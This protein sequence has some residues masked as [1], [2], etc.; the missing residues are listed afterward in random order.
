MVSESSLLC[1]S[2]SPSSILEESTLRALLQAGAVRKVGTPLPSTLSLG[3]WCLPGRGRPQLCVTK[4]ILGKCGREVYSPTPH[5]A[6]HSS[7]NILRPDLRCPSSLGVCRS[8]V[9]RRNQ[10]GYRTTTLGNTSQIGLWGQYYQIEEPP[11]KRNKFNKD[12]TSYLELW[13]TFVIL[14]KP[15]L[16]HD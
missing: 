12:I 16:I 15:I 6:R 14:D 13:G 3:L 9:G 10:E 4:A 11:K 1:P 8:H 7:L 5:P 2:S